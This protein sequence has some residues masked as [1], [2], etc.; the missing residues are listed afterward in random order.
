MFLGERCEVSS[1]H[2]GHLVGRQPGE[3]T[4]E[5][6]SRDDE[7]RQLVS[8]VIADAIAHA[9]EPATTGDAAS[10]SEQEVTP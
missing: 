1:P 8:H 4:D 6:R 2:G 9:Q 10:I 3:G 7:P 5:S